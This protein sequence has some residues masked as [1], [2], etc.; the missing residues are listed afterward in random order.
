MKGI[1]V[2]KVH[3]INGLKPEE[4]L[5]IRRFIPSPGM[6]QTEKTIVAIFENKQIKLFKTRRN[7]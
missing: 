5:R 4:T 6:V 7:Q 3:G 2:E 1:Y